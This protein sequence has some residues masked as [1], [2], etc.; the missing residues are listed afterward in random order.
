MIKVTVQD[1]FQPSFEGSIQK[2]ISA[3]VPGNIAYHWKKMMDE[4]DK[5]RKTSAKDYADF[6]SQYFTKGDDGKEHPIEAKKEEFLEKEKEFSKRE[7][8]LERGPI[9]IADILRI[10]K[11]SVAEIKALEFLTESEPN[12][13]DLTVVS[14]KT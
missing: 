1:L 11:I 4:I 3:T 12:R 2:L 5:V 9:K 8:T 10:D 14:N 13:P 7:V 6:R